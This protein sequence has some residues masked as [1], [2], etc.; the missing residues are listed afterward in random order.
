[1]CFCL[2]TCFFL[3]KIKM[4]PLRLQEYKYQLDM[5]SLFYSKD[6]FK[7]PLKPMISLLSTLQ[8]LKGFLRKSFTF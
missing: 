1:M 8:I 2:S 5:N 3:K 6:L 4:L 7:M